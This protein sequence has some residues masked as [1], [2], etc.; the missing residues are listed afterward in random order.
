MTSY[1]FGP[2]LICQTS[3]FGS[4]ARVWTPGGTGAGLTGPPGASPTGA[5]ATPT[6]TRA[7]RTVCTWEAQLLQEVTGMMATV[8]RNLDSFVV[9][10]QEVQSEGQCIHAYGHKINK[11]HKINQPIMDSLGSLVC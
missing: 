1:L 4:E 5:V 8:S 10:V 7:A 11:Y 9:Q 3:Q 6:T 2:S